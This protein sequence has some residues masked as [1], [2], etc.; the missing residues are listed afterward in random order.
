VD[1]LV[2]EMI[3]AVAVAGLADYCDVFCEEGAYT[4]TETR[5][6]LETASAHGLL[7]RIHADE[8]VSTGGA[9]LAAEM[10]CVSA[11]HLMAISE[12]GIRALAE[13]GTVA[14]LLPGT[15]FFLGQG[16]WAPARKMLD[17][18][19]T[20]ALAT[21]FNPGSSMT[22]SMPF[23]MSLAVIY[24]QLTPLEVL[25]AATYGGAR[26][27]GLDSETGCLAAGYAADAA[28]WSCRNHRELPYFYAVNQL[29]ELVSGGELVTTD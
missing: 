13:A 17:S 27:L 5:R 18:G 12:D 21:D 24:L 16:T 23:I 4:V 14:T 8:F 1:L 9:E 29:A 3:P 10:G 25:Q 22:V 6:I 26:A 28:L 2:D 19:V 11:D 7:T 15:T 20:L